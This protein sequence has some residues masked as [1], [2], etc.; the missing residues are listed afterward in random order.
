M[1]LCRDEIDFAVGE[2]DSAVSENDFA[3]MKLILP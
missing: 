3:V 1:I 2:I